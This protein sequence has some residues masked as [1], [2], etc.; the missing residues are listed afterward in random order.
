[1]LVA[2]LAHQLSVALYLIV[3]GVYFVSVTVLRDRPATSSE[4][5]D[6]T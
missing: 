6:L 1:M 2:D 4:A 3:P 5:G